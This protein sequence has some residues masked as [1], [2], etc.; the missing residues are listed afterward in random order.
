MSAFWNEKMCPVSGQHIDLS[1]VAELSTM[2]ILFSKQW[3]ATYCTSKFHS[4][5]EISC[6]ELVVLLM[7]YNVLVFY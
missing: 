6:S 3:I 2:Y 7:R 5:L 1:P 4:Y